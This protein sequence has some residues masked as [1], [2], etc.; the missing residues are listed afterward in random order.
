LSRTDK[1]K[2][3][4]LHHLV[5]WRRFLRFHNNC[6]NSNYAYIYNL[7]WENFWNGRNFQG[8][9]QKRTFSSH[10]SKT[11]FMFFNYSETI[12]AVVVT[13]LYFRFPYRIYPKRKNVNPCKKLTIVDRCYAAYTRRSSQQWFYTIIPYIY[14]YT[15]SKIGTRKRKVINTHIS[16]NASLVYKY[17]PKNTWTYTGWV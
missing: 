12:V 6:L 8:T 13:I 5:T 11:Q 14:M 4:N 9:S 3:R 7:V 15:I 1:K 10:T 2:K 16:S 17:I